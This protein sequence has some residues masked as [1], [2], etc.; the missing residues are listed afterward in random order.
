MLT[1]E[2]EFLTGVARL[3]NDRGDGPD[4]PP[5]PDR[6]FSALVAT[7]AARGAAA[8]ERA[9]LEWLEAAPPPVI[10]ASA[11]HGRSVVRSYVPPNDDA[12]ASET[13]LPERRKRQERRFPAVIPLHPVVHFTWPQAPSPAMCEALAALARDTSYLGHSA[14]LVRCAVVPT[15]GADQATPA[16][17]RLHP[18]RLGELERRFAAGQRPS[19]GPSLPAPAAGGARPPVSVFG[20]DW[21]VFADAGG[22]RPDA[23]A[24]PSATKAL[25]RAVQAGFAPAAAPE[26]ISGH[27]PDGAPSRQ[28][29]LAAV[30]LLDA[31]WHWSRGR[32]MGLALVLPRALEAAA[33]RARD[34]DAGTPTADALAAE[35]EEQLLHEAL[36]RLRTDHDEEFALDLRLPV[37]RIWRLRH[38]P[39]PATAS[40]RPARYAATATRWASVTPI[41]LD[42]HPKAPGDAEAAVATACTRIGLPPP[43]AA[44]L[45]PHAAIIGAPG[46]R[47]A[48]RHPWARWRLP[49]SLRGRPLTH[50]VITFD[51]SVQGPVMLG[52]GRF[53]GLGLCLPLD[54]AGAL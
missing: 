29:H 23:L 32:F 20:A 46:M 27:T 47:G 28:P 24:A 33:R 9:A 18:G 44:M 38:E 48:A 17:R 30:P 15:R 35:A 37:G 16:R 8:E 2:V 7:W 10:E 50:A 22:F 42:R 12:A 40:L 54:A 51:E 1:I 39:A 3:A 53:C 6:L 5:Q 4:W 52:A 26:W 45:A 13:V 14:S 36:A 21:I 11:C 49:E 31:G 25:L 19:A 41:V 43:A 34:P